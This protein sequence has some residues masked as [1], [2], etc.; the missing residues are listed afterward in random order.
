MR[1]Y[2]KRLIDPLIGYGFRAYHSKPRRYSY[3]GLTVMVHPEVFPPHFTLSTKILMDY[4]SDLTL[5]GKSLLELGCGSGILSLF[6]A[7]KGAK[8]T[9]S[10]IN[11]EA[12]KGLEQD[13]ELNQQEIELIESN[14]FKNIPHSDFDYIIINPPYYPKDPKNN[15]EKAWYC[16]QDFQYFKA[17]FPVLS[18]YC[19]PQNSILMILSQD[20]PL[21]SI[22]AIASQN[23]FQLQPVHSKKIWGETSTIYTLI[24]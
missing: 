17:L 20:C 13:A 4:I 19:T 6:A 16:G 5:S 2:L 22:R 24:K 23:G 3:K 8:V 15:Q 12:L 1:R 14:L 18:K 11:Q 10:D 7:S 21:D 9:A